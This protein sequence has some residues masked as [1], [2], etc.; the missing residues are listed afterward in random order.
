MENAKSNR[1]SFAPYLIIL[2]IVLMGLLIYFNWGKVIK[3]FY[4]PDPHIVSYNASDSQSTLFEY[5]LLI[6]AEIRN[7]GGDGDVV[8]ESTV[9]QGD[10]QWT[11]TTTKHFISKE[12]ARMELKFDEVEGLKGKSSYSVKCYRLG[13]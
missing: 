5:T 1:S 4:P 6:Y 12:T 3:E 7:D 8:F 9:S 13:K 2:I 11:K 10:Q